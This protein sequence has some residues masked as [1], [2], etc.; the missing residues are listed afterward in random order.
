ML[1][2]PTLVLIA[3]AV[4]APLAQ[5]A[6]K[7]PAPA[8][9]LKLLEAPELAMW[10]AYMRGQNRACY[11]A[12]QGILENS[13]VPVDQFRIALALQSRT[14]AELG[15]HKAHVAD[16]ESLLAVHEARYLQDLVRWE[17][18]EALRRV[19]RLDEIKAHA[20]ELG[21]IRNWWVLGPFANDRGAGFDDVLVP[22]TNLDLD[23][24]Y[25]GKNGQIVKLRKLPVTPDDGTIDMG[26][27]FRPNKEVAAYSLCAIWCD[28]PD[29]QIAIRIGSSQAFSLST[30]LKSGK[31]KIFGLSKGDDVE[32]VL[33]FDQ[34]RMNINLKQGWT[35]LAMKHGTSDGTWAYRLRA[36]SITGSIRVASSEKDIRAAL[37]DLPEKQKINAPQDRAGPTNAKYSKLAIREL[38]APKWDRTTRL[39]AKWLTK[40][41]ATLDKSTNAAEYAVISYLS[42]WANKSS[43]RALAGREENKR[44]EQLKTALDL[45]PKAARVAHELAQYYSSTF[46]NPALA[47]EYSSK[48]IK[49][50][51][52]WPEAALFAARVK[53][54]KGMTDEVERVLT[55]LRQAHPQNSSLLRYA[56]YYAGLRRDYKLSNELFERALAID[57]AD[58]YAREILLGRTVASGDLLAALRLARETRKLTPFDTDSRKMAARLY[59]AQ[60]KY[61]L[62]VRELNAALKISPR[63]DETLAQLGETYTIWAD[64]SEGEKSIERRQ[65]ALQAY[66]AAVNANPNRSDLA[67][68]LEFLDG[69]QPIFEAKLQIDI[70]GAIQEALESPITSDEPYEVIYRGRVTVINKDGTTTQYV[71][72]AYRVTSDD[73]RNQLQSVRTPMFGGQQGRCVHACL[74]RTDGEVEQGRRGRFGASFATPEIGD[75]LHLRFRISDIEQSFF[76]EFY[77]DIEVLGDYVPVRHARYSWVLPAG[78]KFY[79]YRTKGA[80]DKVETEVEGRRVW[81]WDVKNLMKIPD[82][83]LAPEAI[84]AAPTIQVSTYE[85]WAD[86]GKWYYNLIRKQMQPSTEMIAEVKAITDGLKTEREKARAVYNWVVTKVRYN[87]DWH[88]GVHGYKP[89]SAGAVFARAIGDCKDK[90]ILICTMMQVAGVK[91]YPV[92]INLESFRGDEDIT[93][94]MPHHFNHAIAYIEYSDGTGQF[95]D[96][97]TTYH[98]FNELPGG[99]AGANVI[100]IKPDGGVKMTIPVPTAEQDNLNDEVLVSFEANNTLKLVVTRTAKGDSAAS[101]RA[102]FQREGDRKRLLEK[103][104]A[105][106]YPGAK[107]SE[108][109]AQGV[110]GIDAEPVIKFT[111]TLPNGYSAKGF[112][113]ALNPRGWGNTQYASLGKRKT[114]LLTTAPFSRTSRWVF[115]LPAGKELAQ[116]PAEFL[117]NSKYLQ[118]RVGAKVE[119]GKLIVDRR[120]ALGG[121]PVQPADYQ[122]F[123][124]EL[125]EFDNAE[126]QNVSFKK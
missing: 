110:D 43:A 26:A 59:A 46:R 73:G 58:T 28:E 85:N 84:Q 106:H 79:T 32:R 7:E 50:N 34:N 77:G 31:G 33:G 29:T 27:I 41:L 35:I 53:G 70:H 49:A 4:Q 68:Y 101:V 123:R 52:D 51:P 102:R 36:T 72:V 18:I 25:T 56:G 2:V 24:E 111:V 10:Q 118:L 94:P 74:Y 15:W 78:F 65:A 16:L 96:G 116:V 120:Y 62:A 103:E 81:T 55:H 54:M 113:V 108:I 48:A 47:D 11:E 100:V 39:P 87:A 69:E 93:L 89:F 20:D 124:R 5:E 98:G 88:F 122:Q 104:W 126:K 97:T 107:V 6:P 92:I 109:S 38:L 95:V 44:R 91:A 115:A 80:P 19:S 30:I 125:I 117:R 64:E 86:F 75:I 67:R 121:K 61:I 3:L 105:R 37:R 12:A 45:D 83:P 114:V 99:D 21:M 60:G 57:S 40:S 90:A 14:A 1:M 63:D 13:G 8:A 76:G 112:K 66:Q 22:E 71:Q 119:D 82:E 17:L 42:A 23:R 9:Q